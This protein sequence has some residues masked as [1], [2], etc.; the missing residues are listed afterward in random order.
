MTA[1]GGLPLQG[2]RWRLGASVLTV[3]TAAIAVWAAV[4]GPLHLYT[5]ADSVLRATVAAAAVQDSGVTLV[6]AAAQ[7]DEPAAVRAGEHIVEATRTGRALYGAPIT[8]VMSG[9]KLPNG[10]TSQLFWRTGSCRV[11]RFVAGGCHLGSGEVVMTQ[12][13]ARQIGVSVGAIVRARVTGRAQPL[14]LRVTG[15]V[16][17]ADLQPH[18]GGATGSRTSRWGTPSAVSWAQSR[19]T[20]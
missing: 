10:D 7:A 4:L 13:G 17:V 1:R 9:V 16:T 15:I 8:T 12:A 19:P 5:A 20:R 2:M 3:V 11:L 6:T 18:T 14:R